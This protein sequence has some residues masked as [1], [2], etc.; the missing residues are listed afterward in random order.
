MCLRNP[1]RCRS[2]TMTILS[3]E[4]ID[5]DGNTLICRADADSAVITI[6]RMCWFFSRVNEYTMSE[7]EFMMRRKKFFLKLT[8]GVRPK[9]DDEFY[10]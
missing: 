7:K 4:I 8:G 6:P 2:L 1:K 3:F 5:K 9:P 10:W